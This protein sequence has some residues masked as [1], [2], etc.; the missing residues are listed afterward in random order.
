MLVIMVASPEK[1]EGRR[2]GPSRPPGPVGPVRT[3]AAAS[4]RPA[5][6]SARLS[7]RSSP[8]LLTGRV[9]VRRPVAARPRS[10][11]R[12]RCS[13]TTLA[14]VQRSVL[15]SS[16]RR[17]A[18]SC[19]GVT[20]RLSFSSRAAA[21]N[22]SRWGGVSSIR[23]HASIFASVRGASS[24]IRYV[25]SMTRSRKSGPPEW[26]TEIDPWSDDWTTIP[27]EQTSRKIP[28]RNL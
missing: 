13:W 9:V 6:T 24:M 17:G 1:G 4:L 20:A 19:A 8:T 15:R 16:G 5:S 11:P 7:R 18:R 26:R 28:A 21:A 27:L 22:A 2:R 12:R 23:F 10:P 25:A 3:R 14:V